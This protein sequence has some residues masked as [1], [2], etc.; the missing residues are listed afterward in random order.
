MAGVETAGVRV[1]CSTELPLICRAKLSGGVDRVT[2]LVPTC[3][4]SAF[5]GVRVTANLVETPAACSLPF[6]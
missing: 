3:T 1:S 5:P 4:V 2:D 6:R